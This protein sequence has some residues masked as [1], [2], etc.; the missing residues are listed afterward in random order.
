MG[1]T[2]LRI[3]WWGWFFCAHDDILTAGLPLKRLSAKEGEVQSFVEM[4]AQMD[5]ILS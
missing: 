5:S 3:G 4:M 2:A 1:K